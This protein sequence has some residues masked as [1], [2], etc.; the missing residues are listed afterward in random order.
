MATVKYGKPPKT[1]PK[2]ERFP[3]VYGTYP[4]APKIPRE[5]K[6]KPQDSSKRDYS[7]SPPLSGDTGTSGLS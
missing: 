6:I 5:V 4:P 2:P 7:K 3:F 1:V